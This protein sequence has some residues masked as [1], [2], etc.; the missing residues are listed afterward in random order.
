MEMNLVQ[1]YKNEKVVFVKI[2]DKT[3][4]TENIKGYPKY[5]LD[6]LIICFSTPIILESKRDTVFLY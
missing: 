4:E 2:Y 6:N 1:S 3:E 5:F